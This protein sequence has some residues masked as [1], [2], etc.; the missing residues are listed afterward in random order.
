[1][2]GNHIERTFFAPL[3]VFHKE[4]KELSFV[5]FNLF[6]S[7][8]DQNGKKFALFCEGA[9]VL[10][11]RF[12]KTTEDLYCAYK[13]KAI[14]TLLDDI[15]GMRG[16]LC[17][18]I[19]DYELQKIWIMNDP[20]GGSHIYK[21]EDDSLIVYTSDLRF[22][23][24][25]LR[26]I[27]KKVEPSQYY[28]AMLMTLGNGAYGYTSYNNISL[29]PIFKYV[30]CSRNGINELTYKIGNKITNHEE[31]LNILLEQAI[32]EIKENISAV[33]KYPGLRKICHLTGGYDSRIV[34]STI[35]S[36]KVEHYSSFMCS[37][38]NTPDS[39]VANGLA[40]AYGV[41]MT[42]DGGFK[43][44]HVIDSIEEDIRL[45]ADF[46]SNMLQF[47]EVTDCLDRN[48]D[49]I[50]LSGG[51]GEYT[52]SF[53][54][55]IFEQEIEARQVLEHLSP[56]MFAKHNGH[57]CLNNY[58][59]DNLIQD[60]EKYL[61][62]KEAE[63]N[64]FFQRMDIMYMEQRNRYFASH[65]TSLISRKTPRFD[66]LYSLAI[67]RIALALPSDKRQI[68]WLGI[69][70][71]NIM[72]PSLSSYVFSSQPSEMALKFFPELS[73]KMLPST[74]PEYDNF[75]SQQR[76]RESIQPTQEHYKLASKIK[77]SIWQVA[78]LDSARKY[79]KKF[80]PDNMDFILK[81]FNEQYIDYL[82]NE[83]LTNRVDIRFLHTV[84]NI[85]IW[86]TYQNVPTDSI[87]YEEIYANE[88]EQ[89]E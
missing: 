73:S 31:P 88:I 57:S 14:S 43:V 1:M 46:C 44:K 3:I 83:R 22:L 8:R 84:K 11:G 18:Y 51:Y 37:G 17:I 77:A 26:S 53:Y 5:K 60:T 75:V 71:M 32:Y 10:G 13:N 50:I 66:P 63:G 23:V 36:E 52:R 28:I 58:Y 82:L 85:L 67:P 59:H 42:R 2:H 24:T 40:A 55:S 27:G 64:D 87:I 76:I 70:I 16:Q 79:C 49:T 34:F 35:L 61:K 81:I 86:L 41:C 12:I 4:S 7:F 56:T 65:I 33:Y 89:K 62:E 30:I 29:L 38:T 25:W 20:M 9:G 72:S 69:S 45:Q 21:Y 78:A 74:P 54:G 48:E 47:C 39:I 80:L 15:Y 19:Y 68:N 6:R